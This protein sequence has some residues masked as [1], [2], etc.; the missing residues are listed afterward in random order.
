MQTMFWF[1]WKYL[2][3]PVIKMSVL[4]EIVLPLDHPLTIPHTIH[5]WHIYLDIPQKSS[6]INQM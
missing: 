6:N 3:V 4:G 2:Y 1:M 5:V